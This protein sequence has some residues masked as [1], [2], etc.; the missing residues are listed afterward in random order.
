MPNPPNIGAISAAAP[1]PRVFRKS[2]LVVLSPMVSRSGTAAPVVISHAGKSYDLPAELPAVSVLRLIALDKDTEDISATEGVIETLRAL[3][4]NEIVD[5]LLA[6]NISY[7]K[8]MVILAYIG[9][10]WNLGRGD[11]GNPPAPETE[12]GA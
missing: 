3:I 6:D 8:L 11:S 9:E 2:R 12:P 7:K 1:A 5:A 10:R 4:G